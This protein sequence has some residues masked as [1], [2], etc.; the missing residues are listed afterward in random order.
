MISKP[1]KFTKIFIVSFMIAL[2]SCTSTPNTD[3]G[4]QSKN[5]ANKVTGLNLGPKG[6]GAIDPKITAGHTFL[7]FKNG[8]DST[9]V[10]NLKLSNP[11][12]NAGS[13]FTTKAES[14]NDKISK[15]ASEIGV[16][17]DTYKFDIPSDKLKDN[18]HDIS[19]TGLK[20][21]DLVSYDGKVYDDSGKV[22]GS[23]KV[24]DKKITKD[25][26]TVDINISVNI[27]IGVNVQ[28][29]VNVSQNQTVTGPTININLPAPPSGPPGPPSSAPTSAPSGGATGA[30]SS[31]SCLQP[32]A[33]HMVTLASGEKVQM[34][35]PPGD[36]G[37]PITENCYK[38]DSSWVVTL[39]DGTKFNLCK[40]PGM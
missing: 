1:G 4:D 10:F 22:V 14:D 38:P 31:S 17:D 20:E 34:C 27:N 8:G 30:S 25:F 16:N 24:K 18:S 39:K 40:P 3:L 12:T 9:I 32:G 21:G 33:N 15:V 28:Q 7:N 19:L 13:N 6:G 37:N 23:E 29:N 11:G 36:T 26:E 35:T 5:T 2:S